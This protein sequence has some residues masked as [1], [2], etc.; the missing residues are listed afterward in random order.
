MRHS[1]LPRSL[2]V[3]LTLA[4]SVLSVGAA[5][6]HQPRTRVDPQEAKASQL[7]SLRAVEGKKHLTSGLQAVDITESDRNRFTRVE[8][9]IQAKFSGVEVSANGAGYQ[10]RIRG[11][12][13]F[14]AGLEPLL[15]VDG[16]PMNSSADLAS[17]N[18]R[19]VVRIEVLK[20]AAASLY[21]VRGGNGVIIVTTHRIP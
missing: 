1:D 21:G 8:Q 12:E 20:D 19:D 13:S 7:D 18:P 9:M 11:V 6:V 4:A 2:R 14:S 16:T 17:I 3:R 10:I 5:C 15:I